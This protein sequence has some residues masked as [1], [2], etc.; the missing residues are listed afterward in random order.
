MAMGIGSKKLLAVDWDKKHL[1]MAVVRGRGGDVELL[2]AVSV[3]IPSEVATDNAESLGAFLREA[4]RQSRVGVKHAILNIPREQVVLNTL[5]LPPTPSEELPSLV[6][7]QIAKELPFAADQAVIDF[8]LS[9]EHDPKS[10]CTPLVAAVRNED[11]DFYRGVAREAG[12]TIE[13][14]GLRPYAN[15]HAVL[16]GNPEARTKSLMVIEVGP[17]LTEIDVVRSGALMF[18]RA[19]SVTLPD[20]AGREAGQ[21]HDSRITSIPIH[22]VESDEASRDAVGRLMGEIVLSVEAYRATEQSVHIDQ[23]VVCGA[24]GL[25]SELSQSLAAR[26]GARAELYSPDRALALSPKRAKELRGFSAVLGLTMGQGQPKLET[27]DFLHPKKPVS[28]RAL[29]LKKA[30]TAILTAA[31][32]IAAGLT[33]HL[34][35]VRPEQ[36]ELEAVQAEITNAKRRERPIK[37]LAKRVKAIEDWTTAEQYWPD[38]LLAMTKAFPIEQEACVTR[39]DFDTKSK[40][41]TKKK[42]KR[43]GKIWVSTMVLKLRTANL[44]VVNKMSERLRDKMGYANVVPGSDTESSGGE[45]GIYRFDTSIKAEL[46]RRTLSEDEP[47]DSAYELDEP[48]DLETGA[49]EPAD[50]ATE[51]VPKEVNA[52]AVVAKE[53]PKPA[54]AIVDDAVKQNEKADKADKADKP[55]KADKQPTSA[56]ADGK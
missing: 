39:L 13:R 29:R 3:P 4:M 53:T 1:R 54:P 22:D 9:G 34:R 56:G 11:L 32:L 30:P 6:R 42:G 44:G 51:P 37:T 10:P 25:E 8:A 40:R 19:A 38:V 47:D 12:L 17:F 52:E 18:S 5:N 46:P 49:E 24:T 7:F 21:I 50:A 45:G 20:F 28:K 14:I 23:I 55:D 33:I 26:F 15:R 2:K 48:L 31:F 36:K 41:S 43:K 35:F 16:A 27:F